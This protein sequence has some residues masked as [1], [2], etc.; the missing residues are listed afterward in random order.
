MHP[1]M[2][3]A[4]NVSEIT[5]L[6]RQELRGADLKSM[7]CVCHQWWKAFGPYLWERVFIDA[8]PDKDDRQV[9]FRNG[10]AAR[11]LTLSIYDA[12]DTRGVIRYVA[13]KCRNVYRLHL[14]LFSPDLVVVKRPGL[15]DG[16]E[17]QK[18]FAMR[19]ESETGLLDE[20]LNQLSFVSELTLS[21]AHEDLQAE[22][23]WCVTSL[24]NLRTLT[25]YG[26]LQFMTTL[27]RK[28]KRCNWA[29]IAQVARGCSSL[30]SLTVG[31]DSPATVTPVP[32]KRIDGI[33]HAPIPS[34][35]SLN[36]CFSNAD[37]SLLE[38]VYPYCP[39]LRELIF[40][41]VKIADYALKQH[42]QVVAAS[43]PRLTS[44][45]FEADTYGAMQIHAHT[46]LD[47]PLLSISS[48]RLSLGRQDPEFIRNINL[49]SSTSF[50]SV[51]HLA[52]VTSY[53]L[54]FKI[55]TSMAGLCR[56]TLSGYL[57]GDG[58]RNRNGYSSVK[59]YYEN[60]RY[61][62][63]RLSEFAC[64]DTLMFLD[65]THLVMSSLKFHALFFQRVQG[66]TQL[67]RLEISHRQLQDARLEET[68]TD[69]ENPDH[70][71][72]A[73]VCPN[74]TIDPG[75]ILDTRLEETQTDL[76]EDPDRLT[77]SSV[78]PDKVIDPRTI[79]RRLKQ[80]LCVFGIAY[81]RTR[82]SDDGPEGGHVPHTGWGSP[83]R[84]SDEVLEAGFHGQVTT[85]PDK[86][87][88]LFPSVEF[89]YVF[90]CN[91]IR[92]YW[93]KEHYISEHMASALVRMMPELKVLAFDRALGEG[94]KRVKQTYPHV[95]FDCIR[96][97]Q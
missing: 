95:I 70:L 23:L 61:L 94:L 96:S 8:D 48:L 77:R 93:E 86:T 87:F 74:E 19:E 38:Q 76:D 27:A 35:R 16:E 30:Q 4:F 83:E 88:I 39:N 89:L 13:E 1:A 84:L 14:K 10:L 56:L 75:M 24:P 25:V 7:V 64:K 28:N 82:D 55:M 34:L 20:L 9:I 29:L 31:W 15:E 44:F 33:S 12:Q 63:S 79:P 97:Q 80:N 50:I 37:P 54:L 51:L 92:G 52:D 59:T 66:L 62:T 2:L 91:P 22:V 73:S 90:D 41:S 43:C 81:V 53:E 18:G 85:L 26:G 45:K 47:G 78:Y 58:A 32:S 65:V 67:K 42:I 40:Q 49:G 5:S 11:S 46:L 3:Q 57:S 71:T 68:W 17:A 6:V 21:I 72:N 36:V 69:D 60:D